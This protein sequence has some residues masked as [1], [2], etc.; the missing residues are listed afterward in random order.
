MRLGRSWRRVQIALRNPPLLQ[1]RP[2]PH[3]SMPTK[4]ARPPP[5]LPATRLASGHAFEYFI[6]AFYTARRLRQ[7]SQLQLAGC[8]AVDRHPAHQP[9]LANI[10]VEPIEQLG[11]RFGISLPGTPYVDKDEKARGTRLDFLD[12]RRCIHSAKR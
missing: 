2:A 1:R 4:H 6:T 8:V 7:D 9:I 3:H 11:S 12:K 5:T 10:A